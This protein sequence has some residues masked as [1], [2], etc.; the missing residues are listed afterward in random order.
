M[1]KIIVSSLQKTWILDI[2]GVIFLHNNYLQGDDI[3]VPGFLEFY[4][5]I[6]EEDFIILLSAR[7]DK[8]AENTT[9]ALRKFHIRYDQI[10]FGMPKGERIIIN[11]TKPGG[12][13]TA[14]ALN[15]KRDI[16]EGLSVVVDKKR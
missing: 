5:Q 8:Y 11:D 2:D 16:M 4:Q 14:I 15:T 6:P 7:E 10:L 1:K 3:L 13:Q 12:L 9:E